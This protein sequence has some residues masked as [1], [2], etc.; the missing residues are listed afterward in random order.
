MDQPARGVTTLT[1]AI[2]RL[3]TAN[4]ISPIS[5]AASAISSDSLKPAN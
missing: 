5:A 2:V 3:E 1:R 4:R